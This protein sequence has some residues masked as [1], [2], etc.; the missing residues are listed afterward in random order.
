MEPTLQ[1]FH[2]GAWVW[3]ETGQGHKGELYQQGSSSQILQPLKLA[4]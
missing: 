1:D 4:G 2:L 3:Q